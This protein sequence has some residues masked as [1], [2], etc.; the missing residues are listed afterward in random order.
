M[1]ES[2]GITLQNLGTANSA[3]WIF[4]SRFVGIWAVATEAILL[5]AA[6]YYMRQVKVR[7]SDSSLSD[8]REHGFFSATWLLVPAIVA[9]AVHLIIVFHAPAVAAPKAP[10]SISQLEETT[11]AQAGE[12]EIMPPASALA[13]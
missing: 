7:A 10:G 11:V 3:L 8:V 12:G 6:F 13:R 4:M 1:I 2:V 5:A 9:I